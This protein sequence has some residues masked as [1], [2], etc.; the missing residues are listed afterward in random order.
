MLRKI[1]VLRSK[2]ILKPY[3]KY[4]VRC[5]ENDI[6]D[7]KQFVNGCNVATYEPLACRRMKADA[8]IQIKQIRRTI[9]KLNHKLNEISLM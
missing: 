4:E 5:A 2:L 3:L 9:E 8:Q 6:A 7:L 1:K